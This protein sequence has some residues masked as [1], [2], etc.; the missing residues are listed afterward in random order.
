MI[1]EWDSVKR[2]DDPREHVAK[3]VFTKDDAD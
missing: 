1:R 3:F 2:F